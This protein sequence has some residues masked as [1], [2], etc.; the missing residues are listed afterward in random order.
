MGERL[1]ETIGFINKNELTLSD[2][3]IK[4]TDYEID[5]KLI[6]FIG[7]RGVDK[8]HFNIDRH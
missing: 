3:L 5:Y 6:V 2:R 8:T 1:G 7:A 4:L